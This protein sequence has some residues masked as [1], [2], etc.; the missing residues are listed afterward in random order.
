MVIVQQR[1]GREKWHKRETAQKR[2]RHGFT[3][4]RNGYFSRPSR[5]SWIEFFY[6]FP[7]YLRV[8]KVNSLP[9]KK[10][11]VSR[12]GVINRNIL[13]EFSLSPLLLLNSITALFFVR[14]FFIIAPHFFCRFSFLFPSPSIPRRLSE[15][16]HRL[17]TNIPPK[18]HKLINNW[19]F[20]SP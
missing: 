1:G 4:S 5:P 2:T 19:N 6:L 13:K 8:W 15:P 14:L 10:D 18:N 16:W 9:V 11:R 7:S 3:S 17:S 20:I 12:S